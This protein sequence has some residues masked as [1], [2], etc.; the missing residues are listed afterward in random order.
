MSDCAN[1]PQD[2]PAPSAGNGAAGGQKFIRRMPR[3]VELL[4][5][6]ASVDPEFRRLLLEERAKAAEALGL[7][8]EPAEA[9]IL[10]AAPRDQLEAIIASTRVEP[11]QRAA[12][13]GRD[14]WKMLLVLGLAGAVTVAL[15]TTP[16]GKRLFRLIQ[17]EQASNKMHE[18]TNTLGCVRNF[19]NPDH[20]AGPQRG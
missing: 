15:V 12:F 10:D 2:E 16:Q 7:Q 5:K 19:G 18:V 17:G 20:H 3:G 8:I 14:I 6:K 4:L 13:I 1:Q 11:E 9:A